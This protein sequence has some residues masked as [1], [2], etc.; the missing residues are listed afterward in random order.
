M[1]I[2][3]YNIRCFLVDTSVEENIRSKERWVIGIV[4]KEDKKELLGERSAKKLEI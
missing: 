3:L 4:V 2:T 1:V